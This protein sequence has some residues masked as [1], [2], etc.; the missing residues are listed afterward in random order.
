MRASELQQSYGGVATVS[1]QQ[2]GMTFYIV[3]LSRGGVGAA[4][5]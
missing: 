2:V 3:L 5:E 4:T 1:L